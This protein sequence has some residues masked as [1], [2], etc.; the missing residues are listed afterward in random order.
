ME[1]LMKIKEFIVNLKERIVVMN[2]YDYF[3]L[4]RLFSTYEIKNIAKLIG[5]YLGGFLL[6]LV[7]FL[8]LGMVPFIGILF[9]IIGVLVGIY[10]LGGIGAVLYDVSQNF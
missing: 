9:K 7:F 6:A 3:P 1:L 10:S 5:I 8:L 2:R 4:N